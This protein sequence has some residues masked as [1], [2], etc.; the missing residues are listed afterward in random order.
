MPCSLPAR[1]PPAVRAGRQGC[2]SRCLGC[3]EQLAEAVPPGE[4]RAEY[5]Q[6]PLV[7]EQIHAALGAALSWS[8][9]TLAWAAKARVTAIRD[10][11]TIETAFTIIQWLIVGLITA[12]VLA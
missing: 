9:T 5:H 1:T 6:R 8:F 4:S 11:V 3:I 2:W 7:A 10:F 12:P